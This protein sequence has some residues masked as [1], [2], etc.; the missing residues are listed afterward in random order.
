MKFLYALLGLCLLL[1]SGC[2]GGNS[3][4]NQP[5]SIAVTPATVTLTP[6][7]TQQF[8]AT[9]SN[10]TNTAVTWQVNSVTGGDVGI[11]TISTSGLYTA[12]ASITT[13]GSVT[14]TAISQADTT[15]TATATVI[16]TP[17]TTAPL[18]PILLSPTSANLLAGAQQTFSAS[19]SGSTANVTWSVSCQSTTGDCGNITQ[20]GVYTAP[21]FPP[22]NGSVTITATVSDNS[23]LPGN[24]PVKIQ[25]SNQSLYGQ[26]AFS[27][28]GRNGTAFSASAG[29]ISFDGQGNVTGGVEDILGN[30]NSPLTI[31]GGSYHVGTDGRGTVTLI[32]SAGSSKWQ[33]VMASHSHVFLTTFDGADVG[34]GT[35]DLQTPAQFA[36]SAIQGGYSFLLEGASS[37]QPSGSLNEAGA[38]T[39]DGAGNIAQGLMDVNDTGTAQTA[40]AVSGSYTSPSSQGRGA[41]TLGSQSFIYYIVDASRLKLLRN[42]ATASGIGDLVK[43][44]AGPFSAAS[45]KGVFATALAGANTSGPASTGGIFTLDGSSAV[46][47]TLDI[48]NKGNVANSQ[49]VTGTYSTADPTTGRTTLSWTASDGTHQFVFYPSANNDLSMIEIDS[50]SA[51]GPAL[52]QL[53]AGFSNASFTGNFATQASGEDFAG[54]FGPLAFSGQ[55]IPNGGSA[56]TG[57]L[58]VNDNGTLATSAALKGSYSF[59][60]TGRA[61][62]NATTG[63]PT[64]SSAIFNMYAADRNRLVFIE[65]D[66]NRVITG[67]LQKQY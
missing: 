51:G 43:Q 64:L 52:S 28:S 62:V 36:S 11:G 20:S 30:A 58:D 57:L 50:I 14:I 5:V 26:Y 29:S 32:T 65:G 12:P 45:F 8:T 56:I 22:P 16:L 67:V 9:V 27:V 59:D 39:T 61:V 47:A 48:N 63:S 34:S 55:L 33:I 6:N 44:P 31:T 17:A 18:S 10:S 19:V 15:K 25:I 66:S 53:L 13:Q 41:L 49:T 46:T 60:A 35:M 54:S 21:Y 4:S 2:G 42:D 37:A 38:F 40:V 7:Q 3:N 24:A 1:A 23:A